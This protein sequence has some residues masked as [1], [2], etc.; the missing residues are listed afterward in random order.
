[1]GRP[2]NFGIS[3]SNMVNLSAVNETCDGDV[4]RFTCVTFRVKGKPHV[5]SKMA[6]STA[7]HVSLN[8]QMCFC[9]RSMGSKPCVN[10]NPWHLCHDIRQ[11]NQFNA[12]K[13]RGL[14]AFTWQPNIF[15]FKCNVTMCASIH[16]N[17]KRFNCIFQSSKRFFFS[18]SPSTHWLICNANNFI[19]Q[20]TSNA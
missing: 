20:E 10:F 11:E 8:A 17:S 13:K 15:L 3:K 16:L 7:F 19:L 2:M 9:N 18:F 4:R 12:E 1:M 6:F 5:L 14:N